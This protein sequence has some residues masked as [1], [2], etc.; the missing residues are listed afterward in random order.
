MSP[1]APPDWVR[2]CGWKK[3]SRRWAGVFVTSPLPVIRA[4][5]GLAIFVI[6]RRPAFLDTLYLSALRTYRKQ[7]NI[8]FQA[9]VLLFSFV[10]KEGWK[11]ENLFFLARKSIIVLVG[12]QFKFIACECS[13]LSSLPAVLA[14]GNDPRQLF[15]QA[16]EL[17][18]KG[19]KYIDRSGPKHLASAFYRFKT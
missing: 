7:H 4:G 16:S 1:H 19:T 9:Q 13:C 8:Q 17:S 6:H 3:Y 10:E 11:R 14:T 2:V 15:S 18:P 12:I 5:H